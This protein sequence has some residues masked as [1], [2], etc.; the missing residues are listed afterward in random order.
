MS[1]HFI[2]EDISTTLIEADP[3]HADNLRSYFSG[4]DTVTIVEA[5]V[6]DHS[7]EMNFASRVHP[8]SSA[9]FH[10]VRH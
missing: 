8:R 5:A 2:N 7:G 1:F 9:R 10:L 6:Y 3:L 4:K